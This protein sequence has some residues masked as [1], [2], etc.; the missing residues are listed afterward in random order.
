M[1]KIYILIFLFSCAQSKLNTSTT[2]N[3]AK[4][5]TDDQRLMVA[6]ADPDETDAAEEAEDES[7]A[8]AVGHYSQFDY[9]LSSFNRGYRHRGNSIPCEGCIAGSYNLSGDSPEGKFQLASGEEFGLKNT[10]FDFPVIL[11]DATKKWIKYFTTNKNGVTGFLRY[12]HR[13]GRYAP[14]LSEILYQNGLPRDLIYLAMAESGFHNNAKSWARAVGPWQFMKFTGKRYG[15]KINWYVDERRDPIK[16]THAA[17]RYLKDLYELFGSWELASAGYNAGEGKIANA[18]RRTSKSGDFWRIRS[19]RYIKKETKEY[20]PKIMA[21]AI[22]GKNLSSFGYDY[23][24]FDQ[25]IE[26][27]TIEVPGNSDLYS[28]AEALD[29]DFQELKNWNP[30]LLRWQT[31]PEVSYFLRVPVGMKEK[32]DG[33]CIGKNF[34]ATMYQEYTL[35]SRMDLKAVARKFNVPFETLSELNKIDEYK[36]LPAGTKIQL[37]FREGQNVKASMY[38]DL[39]EKSS[40]RKGKKV[41]FEK[42]LERALAN[43]ESIKNPREYYT[44]RKGDTLWDVSK[45][46]RVSMDTL[47]KSNYNKVK[48]GVLQPGDVLVVR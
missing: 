2:P 42:T 22:I 20:V 26:F 19:S 16:A 28:I 39:Y 12:S 44:V 27:E 46:T 14:L 34:N 4:N 9:S 6:D 45:R 31:P 25:P 33:C 36:K 18:L 48:G 40:K 35:N 37:P 38:S 47:I 30:E 8:D 7:D 1:S 11:N 10:S 17:S 43:G 23:I 15:L 29:Y 21:L 24:E 32:W 5:L 13:A 41:S 3:H